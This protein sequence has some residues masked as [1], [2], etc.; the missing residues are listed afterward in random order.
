MRKVISL[1]LM[2]LLIM[3][4]MSGAAMAAAQDASVEFGPPPQNPVAEPTPEPDEPDVDAPASEDEPAQKPAPEQSDD[5]SYVEHASDIEPIAPAPE[6]PAPDP[7]PE[8]EPLPE[9]P[10]DEITPK[11]DPNSASGSTG[12]P[13]SAPTANGSTDAV[14]DSVPKTGETDLIP[15]TALLIGLGVVGSIVTFKKSRG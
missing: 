9:A 3:A 8:P 2:I 6:E 15:V 12:N 14:K 7:D 1:A 11:T 5:T 4:F 13:N 10:E